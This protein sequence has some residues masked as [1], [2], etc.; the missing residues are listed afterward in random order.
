M[1]TI[2]DYKSGNLR[3]ISNGFKKI[4]EEVIITD[5]VEVMADA[6]L[7]VLPGVG[8]FGQAMANIEPF[9]NVILEH[10]NDD[11]PFL[12]VCLGQQVLMSSSDESPNVKGLNLFKGH[13]EKLPEG[14]KIPHMGW[15]KLKILN[16]SP[17]LEGVNNEYFYFVHSY[18]VVPND[19]KIISGICDYGIEVVAS[20]HQNN[21]FSTQFHPEKSGIQGLKILKNFVNLKK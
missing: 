18:H 10:I 21:L 5:D 17:I 1:I 13:V 20:L 16:N 8:A 19:E 9:K 15:N 2:I 4:G 11:K 14:R 7:M 12:G 6:D 3:S